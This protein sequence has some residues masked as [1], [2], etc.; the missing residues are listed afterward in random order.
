VAV[1]VGSGK[2]E[3]ELRQEAKALGVQAYFAG[4][5]NQS[6]L[7]L[8][9]VSA[10]V[11]VLP[12]DSGETWGL[13]VNE[14]MACGL[15]AIVSDAV[16]SMPDLIEEYETGFSYPCGNPHGLMERL[17]LLARKKSAGHDW[18]PALNRKLETFSPETA[19]AGTIEAVRALMATG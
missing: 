13:V 10:D 16:G 3:E 8:Q 14:A 15:P 12:S 7:P 17:S 6:E 5:K 4:F 2:L 11:L 18:R 9:Y 19:A 1:F